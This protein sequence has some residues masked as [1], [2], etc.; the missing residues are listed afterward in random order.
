MRRKRKSSK[1]RWTEEE[2][3]WMDFLDSLIGVAAEF[4]KVMLVVFLVPWLHEAGHLLAGYFGRLKL[5]GV[6]YEGYVVTFDSLIVK[7]PREYSFT[8]RLFPK[9]V[10]FD[11]DK[12]EKEGANRQTFIMLAGG[13]VLGMVPFLFFLYFYSG[14]M[15]GIAL[16]FFSAYYFL[17]GCRKD[18]RQMLILSQG[19]RVKDIWIKT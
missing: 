9:A 6:D 8:I 13:V 10:Y 11:L 5:L 2:M 17:K 3:E 7:L 18:M 12:A 14:L 16:L 19:G 1:H 15:A 4:C